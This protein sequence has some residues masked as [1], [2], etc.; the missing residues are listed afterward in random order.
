MFQMS[1][2]MPPSN[3]VFPVPVDWFQRCT[4]PQFLCLQDNRPS[5]E[6]TGTCLTCPM[7]MNSMQ[8]C[9]SVT[10][11]FMSE[12]ISWYYQKVY[13]SKLG[14]MHFLLISENGF[15]SP[16]LKCTSW[17]YQKVSLL[18][19]LNVTELHVFTEFMHSW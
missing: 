5:F 18:K 17:W 9:N 14:K 12:L 15:S 16:M 3:R 1:T 19:K 8:T 13:Y 4:Q 11:Y 10:F 6:T 7:Y 2:Q